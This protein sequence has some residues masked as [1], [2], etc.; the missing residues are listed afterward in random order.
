MPIR[1]STIARVIRPS[2][3][4][5]RRGLSPSPGSAERRSSDWACTSGRGLDQGNIHNRTIVPLVGAQTVA[6]PGVD[7]LTELVSRKTVSSGSRTVALLRTLNA[8]GRLS[9]TSVSEL[10][11]AN[12]VTTSVVDLVGG[13]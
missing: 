6:Q 8:I 10:A 7:T 3:V 5:E 1:I 12:F 13:D 11:I 9:S 4:V 2:A